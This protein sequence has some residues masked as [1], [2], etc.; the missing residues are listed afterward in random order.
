MSSNG[1][2]ETFT[3][4]QFFFNAPTE[5]AIDIIDI[6]HSL[7][8]QCRYSGHTKHFYSVAEHCCLLHDW[9]LDY[10]GVNY[11]SEKYAF[12]CLMHDAGEAYLTDV[13][14]PIKY[15][16]PEYLEFEKKIEAVISKKFDLTHPIPDN[17]KLADASILMDERAQAM[18]DSGHDWNLNLTPLGI[19]LQFWGPKVAEREFLKR[20]YARTSIVERP[21]DSGK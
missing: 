19:T 4:K 2:I 20:Y 7:S 9:Y 18:S 16:L 14:R 6:A 12:E 15:C 5:D 3:G 13:P 11:M 10:H 17:V 8:M 21:C 1:F